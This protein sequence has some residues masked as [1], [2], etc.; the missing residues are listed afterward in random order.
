[1]KP[2]VCG[3]ILLMLLVNTAAASNA[4]LNSSNTRIAI[5]RD[6]ELEAVMEFGK[7]ELGELQIALGVRH[8]LVRS[9][10]G[11]RS[12][13]TIFP[14]QT[15]LLEDLDS[16]GALVWRGPD[17]LART[18]IKPVLGATEEGGV[19]TSGRA[20]KY[21]IE[22]GAG[23]KWSY[24]DGS[25]ARIMWWNGVELVCHSQNGEV[26]E[27][28][29]DGRVVLS[30]RESR[31]R[32]C[33]NWITGAG[34]ASAQLTFDEEGMLR[35]IAVDGSSEYAFNYD[36]GGIIH[37]IALPGRIVS[38]KHRSAS[39]WSYEKYINSRFL[40]NYRTQPTRPNSSNVD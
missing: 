23:I 25:L 4:G 29:L 9:I 26:R 3:H 11:W 35:S 40:W 36:K 37:S 13:F 33:L 5:G 20:G 8:K 12:V 27:M 14:T 38:I 7:I 22:T 28:S 2:K 16:E 39:I 17:G 24:I 1:M 34:R 15:S 6:G 32:I 19:K 18:L 31:D 30:S 21:Q 10:T